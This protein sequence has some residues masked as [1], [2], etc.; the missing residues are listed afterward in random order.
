LLVAEKLMVLSSDEDGM[1]KLLQ[2]KDLESF[3][4]FQAFFFSQ[5]LLKEEKKLKISSKCEKFI[6]KV[7]EQAS[8]L[9]IADGK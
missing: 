2:V 6:A 4:K 7:L 5:R 8:K 9:K 3:R 1:L